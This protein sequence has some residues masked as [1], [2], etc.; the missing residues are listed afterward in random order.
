MSS[1][2]NGQAAVKAGGRAKP[3]RFVKLC[4]PILGPGSPGIVRIGVGKEVTD[5]L[6]ESLPTDFGVGF[7]LT[8]ND[9]EAY[10]I[11]LDMEEG[12]SHLCS[13]KGWSR[14]SSCK[15]VSSLVSL[16]NT[17]TLKVKDGLVT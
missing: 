13:C 9:G 7:R 12:K 8:K 15:H 10:E 4:L 17:G 16:I 1:S 11:N 6:L 5:Y 2:S 14:W 3:P